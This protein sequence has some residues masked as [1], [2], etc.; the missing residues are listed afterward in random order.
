MN[1]INE[2]VGQTLSTFCA[3]LS[4]VYWAAM[5][6]MLTANSSANERVNAI[7][8]LNN[9][10]DKAVEKAQHLET[11]HAKNRVLYDDSVCEYE[12]A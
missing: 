5:E 8:A 11:S 4:T 6:K 1:M 9:L 2:T 12:E 10:M 7:V 3:D